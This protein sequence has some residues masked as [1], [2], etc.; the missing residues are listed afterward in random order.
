MR[1]ALDC[2][3][4]ILDCA[5]AVH[6]AAERILGHELHRS[7]HWHSYSFAESMDLTDE[8]SKRLFEQIARENS[9]SYRVGFYPG[10]TDFVRALRKQGHEVF[11]LTSQWSGLQ[12]WVTAREELLHGAFGSKT[13]IVFTHAKHLASFELLV[14]DRVQTIVHPEIKSRAWLFDRP[15]NKSFDNAAQ[16]VLRVSNY[17]E[18]LEL[19]AA[20]TSAER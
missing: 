10:A 20:A 13:D 3:G 17:A 18:I 6:A 1:I 19:T 11:F 7:E 5:M 4:V 9:L 2:D 12:S 8:E 16:G 15:W 14:D